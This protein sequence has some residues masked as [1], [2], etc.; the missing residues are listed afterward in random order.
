MEVWGIV[1]GWQRWRRLGNGLWR[2]ELTGMSPTDPVPGVGNS[3]WDGSKTGDSLVR[4]ES[5]NGLLCCNWCWN[6]GIRVSC[7]RTSTIFIL[8]YCYLVDYMPVNL[9]TSLNC[10]LFLSTTT[11]PSIVCARV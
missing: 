8:N 10:L 6:S 9:T 3:S 2:L 1:L 7:E 4:L 11:L 5:R